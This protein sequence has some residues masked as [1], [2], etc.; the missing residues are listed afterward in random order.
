MQLLGAAPEGM[1][2]PDVP[3]ALQKGVVK[4]LVSSLEVL[5]DMK[6]AEY[7]KHVTIVDLWVVPFVVVMNKAKWEALP[8]DVKKVFDDLAKDQAIWTGKYVDKHAEDAIAWA[9]KE[10]G[11][12]VVTLTPE[13]RAQWMAKLTAVRDDYLKMTADAKLPGKEFLAD[14]EKIR[15]A[16]LKGGK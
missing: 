10:Q 5:K 6:F 9:K 2:M 11:V 3:E 7:C 14:L 15:D 1:P 16:Y 8:A 12:Q 4:G 13:Q